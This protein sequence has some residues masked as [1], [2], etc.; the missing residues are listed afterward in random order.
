M[1]RNIF[2]TLGV[3][4]GAVLYLIPHHIAPVCEGEHHMSCY[5]SGN[6]VMKFGILIIVINI[7]MILA[8]K[9]KFQKIIKMIGSLGIIVIAALS[10]MIPHG[11]VEVINEVGKPYGFCKMS[12]MQCFINNTFG[13]VGI[14]ATIIVVV[15][16][17]NIIYLFL[18][19]EN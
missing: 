14:V 16:V 2:E 12:T 3:L 11:I 7:I 18:K 15:A 1:K 10:Y 19:R 17:G 5:Y 4:L 8:T 13:L 9:C 6:L